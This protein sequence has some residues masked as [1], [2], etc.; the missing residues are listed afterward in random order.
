MRAHLTLIAL[1]FFPAAASA[2]SKLGPL[3]ILSGSTAIANYDVTS[4]DGCKHTSG[5]LIVVQARTGFYLENGVHVSGVTDNAC[6][7]EVYGFAGYAKGK[8]DV[9]TLAFAHFQG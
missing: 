8:W 1:F 2:Q 7:N 3:A 9:V 5:Q 4:A 6:T